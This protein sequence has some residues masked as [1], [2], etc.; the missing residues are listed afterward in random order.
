VIPLDEFGQ[1][2]WDRAIVADDTTPLTIPLEPGDYRIQVDVAGHGF[3]DVFR[4]VPESAQELPDRAFPHLNWTI[5]PG[6]LR[7]PQIRI[8]PE[9]VSRA[10]MTL[11]TGDQFTMGHPTLALDGAPPH[12]R[13]VESFLIEPSEVTA[14]EY[15]RVVGHLPTN[16]DAEPHQPADEEPLGYV[17]W[18]RAVRFAELSGKRLPSEVEYE[19]VA[20]RRGTADTPWGGP[21]AE[22]SQWHEAGN[23]GD[24]TDDAPPLA[25]LYS[26]PLE[27]T[28]SSALGY[29]DL[30]PE[31][32]G[33]GQAGRP[34]R[35]NQALSTARIVRGGPA[36]ALSGA[37]ALE[38]VRRGPRQRF[39]LP[40]T[41]APYRQM[42][43]RC[44]RNVSI[45]R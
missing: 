39:S 36:S 28:S 34:R 33:G 19:F 4:R 14:A 37:A 38:E 43:F 21:A 17:T 11:I 8:L 26:G 7:L 41:E 5:E 42:G 16:R 35:L 13:L 23:P 18:H 15:R 20:T 30:V 3:H 44:A 40:R 31:A 24:R 1:E 29:Q 10:G 6:R 32:F 25:G 2:H 27:W 45:E 12:P 22:I 9:A